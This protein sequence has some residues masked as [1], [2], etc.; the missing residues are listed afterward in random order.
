MR[1]TWTEVSDFRFYWIHKSNGVHLHAEL[2]RHHLPADMKWVGR[3]QI[4]GS[5]DEKTV[6]SML[7]DVQK[8]TMGEARH[9]VEEAIQDYLAQNAE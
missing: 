1:I 8:D 9:V 2:F 4:T 6:A 7:I 3:L 5:D